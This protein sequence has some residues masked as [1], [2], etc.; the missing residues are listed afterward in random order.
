[1][2][3]FF[4]LHAKTNANLEAV[5]RIVE[6]SLPIDRCDLALMLIAG[7]VAMKRDDMAAAYEQ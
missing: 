6:Q 3:G 5:L 7:R 4:F 2:P 1:M